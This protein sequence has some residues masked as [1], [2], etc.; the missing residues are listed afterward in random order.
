MSN[1]LRRRLRL[2]LT[3]SSIMADAERGLEVL[4]RLDALGIRPSV[5][6]AG[7]LLARRLPLCCLQHVGRQ[8]CAGGIP[9]L[10]DMARMAWQLTRTD[11]QR[12]W[13]GHAREDA[14][15]RSVAGWLAIE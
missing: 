8:V 15:G 10:A 11:I 4:S 5:L 13:Y 14:D 2:E 9:S 3:Q 12:L 7:P 6:R 1:A